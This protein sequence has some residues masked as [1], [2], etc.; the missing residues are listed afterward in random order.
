[1][2]SVQEIDER[3]ETL[4]SELRE[5]EG[6]PTE[7]YARIVGYYRS[8]KN[9]LDNSG[10]TRSVYGTIVKMHRDAPEYVKRAYNMHESGN[11]ILMTWQSAIV[12][13]VKK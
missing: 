12:V 9:W 10:T 6:T 11:D 2:N 3:I 13:G 5:V 4:Q 1:M 8:L 7:I